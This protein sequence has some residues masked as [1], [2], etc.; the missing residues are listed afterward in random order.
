MSKEKFGSVYTINFSGKGSQA[1]M[2]PFQNQ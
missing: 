1:P 2:L